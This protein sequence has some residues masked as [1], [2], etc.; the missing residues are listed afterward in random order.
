MAGEGQ[1]PPSRQALDAAEEADAPVPPSR[2]RHAQRPRT[3]ADHGG[4]GRVARRPSPPPPLP[5]ASA[6]ASPG[7][8]PRPPSP[9]HRGA[10]PEGHPAAAA[11]AARTRSAAQA[12]VEEAAPPRLTL[13]SGGRCLSARVGAI[14]CAQRRALRAPR[15][16][17]WPMASPRR[18]ET[19][20]RA[21]LG[22]AVDRDRSPSW[23]RAR[24]R[25]AWQGTGGE[26]PLAPST[27]APD[28]GPLYPILSDPTLTPRTSACASSRR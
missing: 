1:P 26:P 7:S 10:R 9:A 14:V 13:L 16:T 4:P 23:R 17:W 5:R 11:R 27:C 2:P 24:R 28:G 6:R 25:T 19:M 18:G 15:S 12:A 3:E 21:G 22:A 8:L 20:L